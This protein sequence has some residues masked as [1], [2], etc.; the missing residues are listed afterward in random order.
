MAC[1]ILLVRVVCGYRR[2]STVDDDYIAVGTAT[3]FIAAASSSRI[4]SND[5]H[6]RLMTTARMRIG[7]G[8]YLRR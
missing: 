4:N 3:V 5:R 7:G 8:Q 6:P 2:P 1:Q